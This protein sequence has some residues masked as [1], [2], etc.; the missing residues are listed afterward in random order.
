MQ[1][2]LVDDGESDST[3][4]VSGPQTLNKLCMFY[5]EL[6]D[7]DDVTDVEMV[8]HGKRW[9]VYY[10]DC[11]GNRRHAFADAM[12]ADQRRQL[13]LSVDNLFPEGGSPVVRSI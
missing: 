13:L 8:V 11:D 4:V 3:T 12:S 6:Q 5:S 2:L 1:T 9:S 7:N 10:T